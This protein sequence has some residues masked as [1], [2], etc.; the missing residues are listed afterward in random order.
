MEECVSRFLS[1]TN[2]T[3]L[4]KASNMINIILPDFA[5]Y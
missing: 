1:C 4:R 5:S 2:D 3:K